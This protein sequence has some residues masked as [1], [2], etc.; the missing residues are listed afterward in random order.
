MYCSIDD[1]FSI[2]AQ[3]EI[4]QL[5]NDENRSAEDIVL[6]DSDDVCVVRLNT[7]INSASE[8]ID[9]YL[10]GRYTL[11]LSSTPTIVKLICV[12]LAYHSLFKRRNAGSERMEPM[13]V[14][15]TLAERKLADIRKGV[16]N[17]PNELIS[18]GLVGGVLTNKTDDD[19]IFTDLRNLMP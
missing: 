17:L 16:I 7:A 10:R 8:E 3:A 11:P 18:G 15:R 1:L 4:L 14:L 5:V 19:R 6:T 13:Q 9:G 2:S 12:D